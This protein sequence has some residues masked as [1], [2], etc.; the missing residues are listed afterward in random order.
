MKRLS[1]INDI[2]ICRKTNVVTFF[3]VKNIRTHLPIIND[4][5]VIYSF[6][7][8]VN[9]KKSKNSVNSSLMYNS[10]F[11]IEKQITNYLDGTVFAGYV[12]WEL[13][14]DIVIDNHNDIKFVI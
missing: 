9:T 13:L 10:Y 1:W 11:A 3:I 12:T 14:F 6:V 4:S 2:V 8:S 7:L 5:Y